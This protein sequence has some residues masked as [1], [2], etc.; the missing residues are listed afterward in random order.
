LKKQNRVYDSFNIDV[1]EKVVHVGMCSDSEE[2][3]RW[4]NELMDHD[5]EHDDSYPCEALN[6]YDDEGDQWI[7]FVKD[8]FSLNTCAHECFHLT[9]HM[10]RDIGH[11]FKIRDHEPHAWLHG[12][13]VDKVYSTALELKKKVK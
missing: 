7:I 10:M 6:F 3:E 5:G 13:V 4:S 1:Y 12:F 8:H 11:K 9:H 2:L